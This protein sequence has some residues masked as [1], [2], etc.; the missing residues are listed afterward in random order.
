MLQLARAVFCL[1]RQ[2]VPPSQHHHYHPTTTATKNY[3]RSA[4]ALTLT[5]TSRLALAPSRTNRAQPSG[6]YNNNNNNN[7]RLWA[8]LP[9]TSGIRK[10][11]ATNPKVFLTD[12][13]FERSWWFILF[14]CLIWYVKP[15]TRAD[16]PHGGQHTVSTRSAHGQHDCR[17]NS[18]RMCLW[19]GPSGWQSVIRNP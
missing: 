9:R 5:L 16:T 8:L 3:V 4:Q 2:S 19:C 14:V 10:V 13:L 18:V 15:P 17:T 7:N 11:I 1:C 6:R 12:Q